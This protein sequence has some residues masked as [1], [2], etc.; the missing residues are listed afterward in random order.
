MN[1][2]SFVYEAGDEAATALLGGVLASAL[3]VPSVVALRGTLGAGKTALVR[4]IAQACG[5]APREVSSPTF[6]LL[7]VYRG[8]TDL[9][10]FDAY[11]LT[12]EHEFREL[13]VEEYFDGAGISLVEWADRVRGCLPE[14][15][16]DI[17]IRVTGPTSR[18]FTLTAAGAKYV[19][20]VR[21]IAAKL[22][23]GG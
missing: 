7:H 23:A 11:R 13:G 14:E 16:L 18:R 4:A 3:P 6:V 1:G 15:H 10:H 17:E 22:P 21:H 5:I 19:D 9:F 12:G 8:R 20:A 2:T